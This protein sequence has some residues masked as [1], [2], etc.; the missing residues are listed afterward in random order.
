MSKFA[1]PY[2]PRSKADL[3][4][5]LSGPHSML[6]LQSV[7]LFKLNLW[8]AS[9]REVLL[10]ETSMDS[11]VVALRSLAALLRLPQL[12][13]VD[14]ARLRPKLRC[15]RPED[16]SSRAS[17][18]SCT[19]ASIFWFSSSSAMS[20]TTTTTSVSVYSPKALQAVQAK[21]SKAS[22]CSFLCHLY[23]S[24]SAIEECITKLKHVLLTGLCGWRNAGGFRIRVSAC[25]RKAQE[26]GT[27][28][29]TLVV[30]QRVVYSVDV[31]LSTRHHPHVL[32]LNPG[33]PFSSLLRPALISLPLFKRTQKK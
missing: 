13:P 21:E 4:A 2:H 26:R 20:P 24:E 1:S 10:C 23:Q 17:D 6:L 7:E 32:I 25:G 31:M 28:A 14:L 15:L 11:A 29:T 16:V 22:E 12:F 8:K 18:K 30:A 27:P 3:L 33:R 9:R 19:K 5:E